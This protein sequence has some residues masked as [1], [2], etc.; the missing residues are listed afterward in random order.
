MDQQTEET[1]AELASCVA[2][3]RSELLRVKTIQTTLDTGDGLQRALQGLT[4]ALL[5]ATVAALRERQGIT[6]R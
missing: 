4:G 3:W 5:A 1:R 6:T 2:R